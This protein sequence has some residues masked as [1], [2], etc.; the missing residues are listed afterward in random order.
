MASKL[1]GRDP[2]EAHDLS[3]EATSNHERPRAPEISS[4][5]LDL[6][7]LRRPLAATAIRQLPSR[8]RTDKP[9]KTSFFRVRAGEEFSIETGVL[10][11]G[12]GGR[13]E[14][15]LVM[16]SPEEMGAIGALIIPVVIRLV[17][18]REGV[19]HTWPVKIP[20]TERPN[21][22]HQTA[23]NAAQR[24][25]RSW[26]RVAANMTL[27]EYEIYEA[28]DDLGDARFPDEPFSATLTRAFEGHVIETID[29]P[30]LRALRGEL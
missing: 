7:R 25:E 8:P 22:W 23:W 3:P 12:E 14:P 2:S 1:D 18:T 21:R 15:F 11:L 16:L 24:A 20:S 29:H 6:Q 26:V 28:C 5:V 9:S 10:E 13:G 19:I 27:G 30:A 4:R 17:A